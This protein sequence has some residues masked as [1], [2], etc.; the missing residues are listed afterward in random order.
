LLSFSKWIYL[1]VEYWRCFQYKIYSMIPWAAIWGSFCYFIA[2]DLAEVVVFCRY[3]FL[4]GSF[5]GIYS[6]CCKLGS[7]GYVSDVIFW[8]NIDKVEF[9]IWWR[10][11]MWYIAV[12]MSIFEWF[13]DLAILVWDCYEQTAHIV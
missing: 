4:P 10:C 9:S 7:S 8:S 13:I 5:D 12:F 1:T 3:Q 6:F 2:K 11:I